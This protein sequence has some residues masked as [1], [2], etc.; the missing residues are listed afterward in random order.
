[1]FLPPDNVICLFKSLS[2]CNSFDL[3]KDFEDLEGFL[4][5]FGSRLP[6]KKAFGPPKVGF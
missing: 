1:M 2:L 3:L 5:H 6:T 4:I